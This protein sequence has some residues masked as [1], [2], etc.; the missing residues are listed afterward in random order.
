MTSLVVGGGE[1]FSP[2][3]TSIMD[4]ASK[5]APVMKYL[6]ICLS[7]SAYGLPQDQAVRKERRIR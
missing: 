6:F 3:P 5:T 2:Q 7:P 4:P 1:D